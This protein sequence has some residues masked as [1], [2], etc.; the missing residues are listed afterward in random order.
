MSATVATTTVGTSATTNSASGAEATANWTAADCSAA[1][2]STARYSAG[3]T[4]EAGT[5]GEPR[6]AR[7]AWPAEKAGASAEA[8]EPR[9]GADEQSTGEP[10]RSIVTIRRT[11]VGGVAVV[12]VGA[13]WCWSKI[14]WADPDSDGDSLCACV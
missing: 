14:A 8:V 11:G 9:A 13:D 4:N 5:A 1:N 7:E 6:T 2:S 3:T 10:P 12:A